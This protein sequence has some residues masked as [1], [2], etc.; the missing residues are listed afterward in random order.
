LSDQSLPDLPVPS[1]WPRNV[2]SAVLHV[3]SLAQFALTYTRGWAADALNPHAR[4]AA[5]MDRL[6]GE[7]ALLQEQVRIQ[8]A[9]LAKIPARR[10]KAVRREKTEDRRPKTEDRRPKKALPPSVLGL[11]FSVLGLVRPG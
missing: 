10:G 11:R 3:T 1:G 6:T 8:N 7:V 2:K 9:R 5:E 4:Q